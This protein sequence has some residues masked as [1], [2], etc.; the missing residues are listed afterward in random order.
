MR[1][2]K[3]FLVFMEPGSLAYLIIDAL[4]FAQCLLFMV[5]LAGLHRQGNPANRFLIAFL[6]IYAVNYLTGF[7]ES[8]DFDYQAP[9]LFFLDD[10]FDLLLGPLVYFYVDEMING[11][12]PRNGWP[13]W[14]H[15]VLPF[16]AANL[17]FLP[18]YLMP[19]DAVIALFI[20]NNDL[21]PD[22]LETLGVSVE[23]TLAAI[24][25]TLFAILLFLTQVTTYLIVSIRLLRRHNRHIQQIYSNVDKKNLNWLRILL[26]LLTISWL[27]YAPSAFADLLF[28]IPDWIWIAVAVLELTIIY[29]LGV[30]AMRQ[31]TVFT[32]QEDLTLVKTLG[33][34]A[35][36]APGSDTAKYARSALEQTD[37]ERI[38]A[39]LTAAMRDDRLY[40]DANLTL[41]NL[42]RHTSVSANYISQV[43]NQELDYNFF[44]FVN[45]YRIEA[46]KQKL[47]EREDTSVLEIALEAGFNSKSTFNAAF[48]RFAG[49][50]PTQFR[51][52]QRANGKSE[53][54]LERPS[55]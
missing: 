30:S 21:E 31:P 55:L 5:F 8:L 36:E 3:L 32:R 37:R 28:D 1:E 27:T 53:S 40:L 45:R 29:G 6:A 52:V 42:S 24:F 47:M 25:G 11:P 2:T 26:T 38:L 46:V 35:E 51:S 33:E 9:F 34:A 12:W 49:M 13:R 4:G 10:T 44:D 15:L 20:D 43:I 54:I 19:D 48:K 22:D 16:V 50:T 7:F 41:A 14:R 23:H 17:L 18:V 39:K